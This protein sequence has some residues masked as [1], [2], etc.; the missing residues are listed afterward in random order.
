MFASSRLITL[1]CAAL[2]VVG[3]S[4]VLAAYPDKP[5]HLVVSTSPGGG[6]DVTARLL[7]PELSKRLGQTIIVDN[8]P[9][10]SGMIA[11]KY[12]AD[13]RADGYTY[14]FDITTAAVNPSLY[15]NMPYTPL[16]DLVPVTQVLQAPN[17]LVV[18]PSVPVS[19]VQEFIAYAKSKNG[20]LAYA[21][22]GN[23][24][25][26]HLAGEMFKDRTG[27][28]MTHVPY[29][30]G[31]PALADVVAGHVPVFFAFLASAAPHIKAGRLKAIA[32]AGNARSPLL[33]DVP[34][35]AESGLPG[36]EVYDFNGFFAPAGT[37]PE[38]INRM[39]R[40]LAATLATPTVRA[41]LEALGAEPV[42][43]TPQEFESF[44]R[45]E[46]KKWGEVI[47]KANIKIE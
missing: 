24:S 25:A 4:P 36:F 21:S 9:G 6:A 39:Q 46:I 11:G 41:Q 32:L 13:Q 31:G 43:N 22:S 2:A 26:Q 18:N 27:I 47:K 33:P 15:A 16:K 12:V 38:A 7:V 35:I 44:L 34:T 8:K 45:N 42:G 29:K 10:A 23:G 20:D 40:D 28:K 19:T 30:G 5:I 14:L 3:S 17:V 1:L 37:P